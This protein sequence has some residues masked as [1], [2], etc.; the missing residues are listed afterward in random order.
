LADCTTLRLRYLDT[1]H[2]LVSLLYWILLVLGARSL[3]EF[4]SRSF[5]GARAL[6]RAHLWMEQMHLV[7]GAEAPALRM[8]GTG[9]RV[10]RAEGS[11]PD[12]VTAVYVLARRE[13]VALAH[14]RDEL[15]R[16]HW[17][18]VRREPKM[19][20]IALDDWD[21]YVT[22]TW[23]TYRAKLPDAQALRSWQ[24]PHCVLFLQGLDVMDDSI[25]IL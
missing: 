11:H 7:R 25:R 10:H 15:D 3:F 13:S 12:T 21:R 14:L 19:R 17:V 18:L 24:S 2:L 16:R 6:R 23:P 1:M 8:W 4:A 20:P 9:V 5:G 22:S